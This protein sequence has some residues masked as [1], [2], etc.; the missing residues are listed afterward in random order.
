MYLPTTAILTCFFGLTT[1]STNFRQFVRSGG[2]VVDL[3]QLADEVVQP[4]VM[5]HER[6]FVNRVFDVPRLDHRLA[7][8]RCKTSKASGATSASSGCSVRQSKT[9]GCK[10]ISRSFAMLCWVGFVFS[11]PRR[12]DVRNERDV[13]V[14]DILRADFEDELPDRFQKR[15]PLDVARRSADFRDDNVGFALDPRPRECD[16]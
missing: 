5:Q 2:G 10:P 6:H 13:H 15:Q 11:S 4:L 7:A 3:E 9:C 8:R 12:L 1:R 16:S 14:H